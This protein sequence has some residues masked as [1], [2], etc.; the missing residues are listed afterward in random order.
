MITTTGW[1]SC[2]SVNPEEVLM[3]TSSMEEKLQ[4]FHKQWVSLYDIIVFFLKYFGLC[5]IIFLLL[6]LSQNLIK[7]KKKV[8]FTLLGVFFVISF[9]AASFITY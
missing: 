2:A 8:Y 1:K 4:D 5:Y 6:K 3:I 9:F 7:C